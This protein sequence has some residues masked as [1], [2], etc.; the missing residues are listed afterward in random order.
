MIF[1]VVPEVTPIILTAP[2]STPAPSIGDRIF[3][4]TGSLGEGVGVGT[5][6][7]RAVGVAVNTGDGVAV[8]VTI[9]D[10][11][12]DVGIEGEVSG[13]NL[14]AITGVLV[15]TAIG[16]SVGAIVGTMV[17]DKVGTIVA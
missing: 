5:W 13:V 8:A 6:T 2:T 11:G 10:K 15:G 3:K 7:G 9:E 12:V 14:E 16:V 1:T 17:S 4:E